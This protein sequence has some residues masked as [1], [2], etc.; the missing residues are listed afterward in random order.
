M[1]FGGRSISPD[2]GVVVTV[3]LPDLLPRTDLLGDPT[4]EPF[5]R[6]EGFIFGTLLVL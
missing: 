2:E 5:C 1:A 3:Q 4:F 6:S